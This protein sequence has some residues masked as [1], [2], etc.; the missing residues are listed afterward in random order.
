MSTNQIPTPRVLLS[1]DYEPWYALV[2]RFDGLSDPDERRDLDGG[3]THW[4][5]D[6][7]LEKL[8]DAKISFYLVGEVADWY[9]EVP[10]KIVAAG[11]ELGFHCQIHRP[12]VTVEDIGKD[13]RRSARW[14]EQYGVRG[15]RA[16]MVHTIEGIYLALE[17]TGFSYSSSIYGGAGHLLRKGNIWEIPVSTYRL[18]GQEDSSLQAPRHLTLKLLFGGELPY[19]SA[20]TIG[21][22]KKSVLRILEKELSLGRSPVIIMH[23]YEIV[24]PENWPRR[25]GMDLLT[26]PQLLPFTVNKSG[27]LNEVLQSFPVSSLGSYLDEA[28]AL[29]GGT[30]A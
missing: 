17:E 14:R 23:P 3:F 20:F 13:L 30:G 24:P 26:H 19:G 9:P 22:L 6:R 1:I 7:I 25:L 28:L 29:R 5:I 2:R 11:H 10:Q 12:L 4:A 8:G 16:P 21:L 27:F 15:Y 18:F